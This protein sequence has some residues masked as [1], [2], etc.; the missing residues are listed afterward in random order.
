MAQ[1]WS[2][3]GPNWPPGVVPEDVA[4]KSTKM[5]QNGQNWTQIHQKSPKFPK[6]PQSIF[7]FVG[8]N[9]RDDG[10]GQTGGISVKNHQFWMPVIKTKNKYWKICGETKKKK[11]KI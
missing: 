4:P 5:D 6:I 7:R 3:I 1:N 11:K 10:P 8:E 2:K 9:A